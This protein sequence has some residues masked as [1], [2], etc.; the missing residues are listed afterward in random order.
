[1]DEKVTFTYER[2][3]S[4][5]WIGTSPER[6]GILIVERDLATALEQTGIVLRAIGETLPKD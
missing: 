1:M 6:H 4:G 3:P 2:Q 5:M